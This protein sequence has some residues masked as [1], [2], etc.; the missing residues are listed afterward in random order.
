MNAGP[1]IFVIGL[2][3]IAV[4]VTW[5]LTGVPVGNTGPLSPGIPTPLPTPGSMAGTVTP[6]PGNLPPSG[7]GEQEV[8]VQ[9]GQITAPVTPAPQSTQQVSSDD[10]KLH[11]VD[12]AFGA[13][14]T[15]L[16]LW[17]ATD[18]NGR[19]VIAVSGGNDRD[20]MLLS[21]AA[22]EFNSLSQ[23]TQLSGMIKEGMNGN[24]VIKFIP[25]EGM[26]DIAVNTSDSLTN[27]D[28]RI[29]GSTVAEVTPGIIYIDGNLRGDQRN[30]TLMRSLYYELGVTGETQKY[31]DSLFYSGENT[32]VN[33][34][35]VDRGAI[36]ILFGPG[37]HSG[38]TADDVRKII[39][40]Q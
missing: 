9:A 10:I 4:G 7:S 33:L 21:D 26:G 30:H 28:V 40:P 39:S 16:E 14:N 6:V 37:L 34:T 29:N 19:I 18:N 25:R 15:Y 1:V 36:A 11:V 17:N 22:Q 12:L 5:I 38:M 24:I 27:H 13:G 2:I 32:N 35:Y 20:T 8:S 23:T 31:P 3:V